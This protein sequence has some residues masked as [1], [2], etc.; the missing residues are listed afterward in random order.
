MKR[1]ELKQRRD[2][3]GMTQDDLAI[4]LGVKMLTV[5]RWER[6][7]YPIP[8]YIELALETIENRKREAA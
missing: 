2:A 8:H 4:A 6:G 7:V 3:L 1:E 5:S